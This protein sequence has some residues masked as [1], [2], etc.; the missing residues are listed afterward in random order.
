MDLFMSVDNNTIY[1]KR[2]RTRMEIC[3]SAPSTTIG[4]KPLGQ[5]QE[6]IQTCLHRAV[7]CL[8]KDLPF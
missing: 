7:D 8:R 2:R 1:I 5:S 3:K 4:E 6:D